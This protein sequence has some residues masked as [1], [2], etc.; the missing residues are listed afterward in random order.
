MGTLC[1]ALLAAG[2]G[3]TAAPVAADPIRSATADARDVLA[4]VQILQAKTSV[5]LRRYQVALEQVAATV[6]ASIQAGDEELASAQEADRAQQVLDGRVRTLYI[7]GGRAGIY[8]AI[9]GAN[10]LVDVT[11]RIEA[12]HRLVSDGRESAQGRA[13]VASDARVAAAAAHERALSQTRTA[14]DVLSAATDLQQL[15]DA[16]QVLLSAANSTVHRLKAARDALA[17]A[18][19]AAAQITANGARRVGPMPGSAAYFALYHAAAPTCPGLSW[20]VL[21]AIGQVESGHGR[22]MGTSTAGAQGPMQFMPATFA[23]YAVD[24]DHDGRK[25]ILNP[26]DAIY[27]AAHYLCANGAGHGPAGVRRALLRY[28]HAEW[29]V[30]MVVALAARYEAGG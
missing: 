30:E 10:G 20:S 26:A 1:A 6:T 27:T 14:R 3:L 15:L 7:S 19:A 16:Q 11:S 21:A 18:R 12:M 22:N 25:D 4:R 23:R 29:Y 13:T 8:S 24:G 9:L 2:G 17:A 28:N 5:A